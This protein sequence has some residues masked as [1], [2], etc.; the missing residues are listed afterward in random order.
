MAAKHGADGSAS[1]PPRRVVG[2]RYDPAEGLPQVVLKSVGK[3]ADEVIW[4]S[5]R[6]SGPSLVKDPRLLEAL[7]RLPVES[8]I[9]PQ[10]FELVAIVLVHVAAV[11]GKLENLLQQERTR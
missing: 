4:E 2:L 10:L 8:D 5:Q 3:S 9:P 7:Y 1:G 6:R 11:D